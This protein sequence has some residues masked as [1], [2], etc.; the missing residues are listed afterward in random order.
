M[1]R[2]LM[3]VMMCTDLA[4]VLDISGKISCHKFLDISAAASDYLDPLSLKHILGTLTHISCQHHYHSHLLQ[5]RGDSALA[6]TSFRRCHP[7]DSSNLAVDHIK[8]CII[9]AMSE[10]VIH[11][12]V[13][14]WYCYLHLSSYAGMADTT[15]NLVIF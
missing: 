2:F 10:V 1:F 6:A 15:T 4:V 13:S 5:H 14:C 8:N 11:A 12:S 9:C 7:A 3:T